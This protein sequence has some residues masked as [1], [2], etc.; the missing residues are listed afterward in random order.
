MIPG[1]P[2]TQTT[3]LRQKSLTWIGAMLGLMA[4][5]LLAR[6]LHLDTESLWLD[7]L[8]SVQFAKEPVAQL[9]SQWMA[10]ETN[11]PLYYTLLHEW[12][13]VFGDSDAALRAMSVLAGVAV[14]LVGARVAREIFT[15]SAAYWALAFLSVCSTQIYYS[16]EARPGIFTQLAA[17]A[18]LLGAVQF[19]T[20]ACQHGPRPRGWVAPWALYIVSTTVALYL[21]TTMFVLP[22]TL[23]IT[24][25]MLILL[26]ASAPLRW[27][28]L[29]WWIAAN[30]LCVVAWAW[31]IQITLAQIHGGANAN[32]SWM[33]VPTLRDLI[34]VSARLYGTRSLG[35]A[36][37]LTALVFMALVVAAMRRSRWT[38]AQVTVV[39]AAVLP[40][41]VL[42]LVSQFKPIFMER[43]A[44]WSQGA[45]LV[46]MAGAADRMMQRREGLVPWRVAPVLI[47]LIFLGDTWH[48]E[49]H[50]AKEP[51]RQALTHVAANAAA[52]DVIM[53][54]TPAYG[55]AVTHYLQQ[56]RCAVRVIAVDDGQSAGRWGRD[57]FDGQKISPT[58]A[59]QL[60][61]T[62]RHRTWLLERSTTS[63]M[64]YL[65]S[66]TKTT[67]ITFTRAGVTPITIYLLDPANP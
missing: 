17:L 21:H 18:A 4:L 52:N 2:T 27:R 39:A 23:G 32:I 49:Q 24:V 57:T 10:Q 11:P 19:I 64:H 38:P 59:T 35:V 50:N 22:L 44:L 55:G 34:V 12:I 60:L 3:A 14:V 15:V 66:Q 6:V 13:G 40:P 8:A 47:L 1:A 20:A 65:P 36:N 62:S 46:L 25:G 9:W 54:D 56:L 28:I 53:V 41:I 37:A 29:G 31:W 51:W 61:S 26:R 45:F 48:A 43:T 63:P 33:V 67:A 7:E 42:W 5:A 30:A 16:N 58:E